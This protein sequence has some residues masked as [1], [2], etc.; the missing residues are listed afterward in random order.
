[1]NQNNKKVLLTG[2]LAIS[3]GLVSCVD[4][5]W[6]LTE[7]NIDLTVGSSIDL[8]LPGCSTGTIELKNIIDLEEDGVVKLVSNP[9]GGDDIYVVCE[10]GKADIDPI[11]IER[12]EIQKP[13]INDFQTQADIRALLDG[14]LPVKG[15]K[16][17]PKKITIQ[18]GG[19]SVPLPDDSYHYDIKEGEATQSLKGA[20]AEN[21]STDILEI[22]DIKFDETTITLKLSVTGFPAHIP[23]MH[24][25][26]IVLTMPEELHVTSCKL[27][28]QDVESVQPGK[29]QLTK[30]EDPR[31]STNEPLILTLSIDEAQMGENF[32][33]DGAKHRAELKGDFAITGSFRINVADMDADAI[34]A[35][36]DEESKNWDLERL[37][38]FSKNPNL[39]EVDGIIPE[40]LNFKGETNFDKNIHI[41]HV[42]GKFQHA[43]GRIDP[44]KLD[45][46][47]DFMNDDDV[48]LD[49]D[50]PMLFLK[51][52][53][54]LPAV[55]QTKA[56][57]T[58]RY[59]GSSEV[60][61]VDLSLK[62]GNVTYWTANKQDNTYMP[63]EYKGKSI[64]WLQLKDAKNADADLT[65][66]IKRVP[67]Q[68]E[69]DVDK[70]TMTAENLDITKAYDIDLDY[71]I[72]A[73]L[74]FGPN[75]YLVYQDTED[76]L[77]LGDDMDDIDLGTLSVNID[78]DVTS[79]LPAG[80]T[81]KVEPL[82]KY[83]Q[84]LKTLEPISIEVPT[85]QPGKKQKINLALKPTAGHVLNESL[86][87]MWK[88]KENPNQLDGVHY[89]AEIKNPTA[90]EVLTG[91]GSIKLENIKINV[92]GKVSYD[93]N[94]N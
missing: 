88:G 42:S 49:L 24:L 50:N 70:V 16:K 43:I 89:K 76:D 8:T 27:N 86:N 11:H 36:L 56:T 82:N 33:F 19:I 90:G 55:A 60:R 84:I 78:A 32:T 85:L 6:D 69:I 65:G 87:K 73:P 63:E 5:S 93:A 83:G 62:Q 39:R 74:S 17:A 47:P 14:V 12:V 54:E 72:Y 26:N 4:N 77:D 51:T 57:F 44:I 66:L 22:D 45:D 18:A 53:S 15:E 28:G 20:S 92:K 48:V 67:K 1:M 81:L 25:D 21:M 23:Y 94:D 34:S 91:S 10:T 59:E 61:K 38:A 2:A 58:S 3:L 35:L 9:L 46:L 29:I 40:Y 71:E 64:E 37:L 30:A 75:F 52:S 80:F 7:D 13:T 68:I 41:T 79:T 31:R